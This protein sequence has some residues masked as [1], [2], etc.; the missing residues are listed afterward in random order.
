MPT[1]RR[2][3]R[4]YQFVPAIGSALSVQ[5]YNDVGT[6]SGP[7]T[8][9]IREGTLTEILHFADTTHSGSAGGEL[10]TRTGCAWDYALSLQFPGHIV[11]GRLEAAFVEQ[12]VGS[13]AYVFVTF[14]MGD[15]LYWAA[16]KLDARSKRGKCLLTRSQTRFVS[17]ARSVIGLNLAGKGHDML[18]RYLGDDE[19]GKPLWW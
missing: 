9:D 2:E 5:Q 19:Q 11:G 17:D 8:L 12:I 10:C 13:S 6:L 1:Y 7:V 15:P 16:R 18:A 14:W 4:D 3:S